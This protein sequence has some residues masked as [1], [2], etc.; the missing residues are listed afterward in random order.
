MLLGFV[1]GQP[2]SPSLIQFWFDGG[3]LIDDE[4]K[5]NFGKEIE[6]IFEKRSYM[7]EMKQ[8]PEV[9]AF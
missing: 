1:D 4:C 2:L 7:D 3:E 6:E 9:I 8:T 5:K